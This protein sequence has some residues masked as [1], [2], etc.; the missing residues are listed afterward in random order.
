MV[1]D[2][3]FNLDFSLDTFQQLRVELV[4]LEDWLGLESIHVEPEEMNGEDVS[5][6]VKYKNYRFS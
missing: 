1:R 2:S 6:I 5:F 3:A 4:G